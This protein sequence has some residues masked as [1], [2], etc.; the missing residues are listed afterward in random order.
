MNIQD[1]TQYLKEFLQNNLVDPISSRVSSWVYNDEGRIELDKTSFP[2]ILIKATTQPTTKQVNAIGSYK[3]L[4]TDIIEIHI[5]AKM[6]NHYGIGQEKYTGKEIVA[7]ISKEIEALIKNSTN[8]EQF[9]VDCYE[10]IMPVGDLF[11]YDQEQNPTFI[12]RVEMK[13]LN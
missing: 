3:T 4:N 5:K 12:L 9:T 8:Q 1:S 6:G 11:T 10:S 13:Y 2:K 7:E